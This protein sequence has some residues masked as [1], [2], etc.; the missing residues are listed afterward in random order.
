MSL[1]K[2]SVRGGLE[3]TVVSNEVGIDGKGPVNYA[4]DEGTEGD[5]RLG[6][7]SRGQR[8][9]KGRRKRERE[10]LGSQ[11]LEGKFRA[12]FSP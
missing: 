7:Q 10:G 4:C 11:W 8:S 12:K 3:C 6:Q 2:A 5:P 9:G 1:L